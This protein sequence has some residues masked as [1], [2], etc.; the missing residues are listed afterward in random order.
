MDV[1]K[2]FVLIFSI[3]DSIN[4]SNTDSVRLKG[5]ETPK[6]PNST[7]ATDFG[8]R[9]LNYL[10]PPQAGGT[11]FKRG[12]GRP[13]KDFLGVTKSPRPP[14]NQKIKPFVGCVKICLSYLNSKILYIN[15]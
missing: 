6:L 12:P 9:V 1:H 2:S 7:D 10:I 15:V 4:S 11:K 5:Y 3:L 14:A 8:N 13:R